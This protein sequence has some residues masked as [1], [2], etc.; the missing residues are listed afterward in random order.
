MNVFFFFCQGLA[1]IYMLAF[2]TA[3][4]K[5]RKTQRKHELNQKKNKSKRGVA[6]WSYEVEETIICMYQIEYTKE[7]ND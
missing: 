2:W 1:A 5:S 7:N 6:P 3:S 4:D